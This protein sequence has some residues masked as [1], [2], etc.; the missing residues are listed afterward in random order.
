MRKTFFS[1]LLFASLILGLAGCLPGFPFAG[2][3]QATEQSQ[4]LP[5]TGAPEGR[6]GAAALSIQE[7]RH[8]QLFSILPVSV[9]TGKPVEGVQPVET[10]GGL[11]FGFSK[12]RSEMAFIS[13]QTPDCLTACLHRMDL[14]SWKEFKPVAL[15]T[16]FDAWH[17]IPAFDSLKASLPVILNKQTETA[18]VVVLVDRDQA[19]VTHKQ[20]L[21]A[22]I[23]SAA[24]TPQGALA[25]YGTQTDRSGNGSKAY[26]ALL[27]G[28]DLHLLWEKPLPE[29]QFF[30]PGAGEDHSDPTQGEYLNPAAAFSPDGSKLYLVAADQPLMLTVDFQKQTVARARIQP[31][32]SL[33]DHLLALGVRPVHAKIMNG[34]SKDGVLSQDGRYFYVVGQ[35]TRMVKNERGDYDSEITPLGMQVIDTRDGTLVRNVPT[36]A[37]SVSLDLDGRTLLLEGWREGKDGISGP[38][39]ETMDPATWQVTQRLNGTVYPSRLLDGSLA[40]LVIEQNLENKSVIDVYR[41]GGTRPLSQITSS[42][43][44]DWIP[45]P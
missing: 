23:L 11:F 37:S 32:T 29:I 44:L 24:Y 13:G 20:S 8:T 31:R 15:D 40:W 38:W 2:V 39:T 17:I 18:S 41:P 3:P 45:I 1:I 9:D 36:E 5:L 30:I 16:D 7:N 34:V 27:D 14:R 35:E 42:T 25:V 21:P 6:L 19:S 4:P 33:L 22:N 12:D 26:L 43:Y 10:G 28:E